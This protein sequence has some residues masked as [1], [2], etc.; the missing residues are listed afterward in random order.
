MAARIQS[1]ICNRFSWFS[2]YGGSGDRIWLAWDARELKVEILESHQQLLHCKVEI[3]SLHTICLISVVYGANEMVSR[4]A[5]W[6]RISHYSVVSGETPW[7]LFGD[8]NVVLD[9]SKVMGAS[10][11]LTQAFDDFQQCLLEAGLITLPMTGAPFSWH[12]RS[13]GPRSLWKRLDRVL[14]NDFWLVKWPSQFYHSTT[15]ALLTILH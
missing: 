4:R 9:S 3:L 1:S 5:L 15:T 14:V 10:A 12:H 6:E 7:M 8:F 2:D 11:E 13:D